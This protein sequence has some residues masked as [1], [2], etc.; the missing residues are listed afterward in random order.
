MSSDQP[1]EVDEHLTQ[2]LEQQKTLSKPFVSIEFFPPKTEVGVGSLYKVLE[3]LKGFKPLFADV[4]W[5]AGG[6][7]SDLTLELCQG[8]KSRGVT[9]N[10]HLTCTN[11][12]KSLIDSALSSCKASGITNILAL[13]GDPPAGETVWHAADASLKCALDLVNYIRKDYSKDEMCI[14]VA[15]YPEGHPTAMVEVPSLNELSPTELKRYSSSIDENGKETFL[16]CKDDAWKTE[17]NYLKQKIDAGANVIITQMVF[18]PEVYDIFVKDCRAVGINVPILPGIMC[19]SAY[20]GF[21]RMTT[22]CKSRVPLAVNRAIDEANKTLND[23]EEALNEAKERVKAIGIDLVEDMCR[24]F[25]ELGA[26]GLHF[27]TLN[28]SAATTAIC[29]R[30]SDDGTI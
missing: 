7:T 4:T 11:M 30:L 5:G 16:V 28:T 6:S 27:Y 2:L 3:K 22:F 15:G 23:T 20:G 13:R 24:K 1:I 21:K 19:I 8:I 10:L 14:T 18:D 9:P 17:M 26:P 12:E 29:N 25:I